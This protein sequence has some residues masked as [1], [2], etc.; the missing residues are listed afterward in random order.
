MNLAVELQRDQQPEL[1]NDHVTVYVRA[2]DQ[3]G[4]E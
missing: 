3:A 4:L 2:A 1:L